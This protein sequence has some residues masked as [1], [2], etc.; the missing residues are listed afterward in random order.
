MPCFFIDLHDGTEVAHDKDGYEL[1]DLDAARAQALRIMI[2]IAQGLSDSPG[3]QD[4]VAAV[5]DAEGAVRWRFRMSL[6]TNP[7]E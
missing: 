4:Y 1:P 5:R 6:D 2:R 3:R 7:V